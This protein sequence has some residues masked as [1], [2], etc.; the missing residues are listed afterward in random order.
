MNSIVI[1]KINLDDFS[2]SLPEGKI[3]KY[4]LKDRSASKLLFAELNSGSISHHK[5]SDIGTLIP[6]GSGLFL[7]NTK[8]IHARLQM[9]KS[10]GGKAELLLTE[11]V[12]PSVDPQIVMSS[13]SPVVWNCILGG[14]RVL[15]GDI[16]KPENEY[17]Q[18]EAEI[19]SKSD[20]KVTARICWDSNITFSELLGE[21]GK[22]PLPPY[23][24]REAT[25]EDD[26]TYN[27]VYAA[28]EGS[29]A[30]PTAGLH[31]TDKIFKEL[32]SKSVAIDKLSLHVGLGTFIPIS[33]SSIENHDMHSE[34][35]FTDIN[36]IKSINRKINANGK[37]IATGTTSLRTIESIFWYGIKLFNSIENNSGYICDQWT[38][39]D[40]SLKSLSPS[41]SLEIV[42]NHLEKNNI[43]ILNGFTK[44]LIAPG[45]NF[46]IINGLITNY[47]LPKST[48]ILLVAA[49]TGRD[50][51]RK[52][53]DSALN[54]DYRFLSYG[55]SSFLLK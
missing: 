48:L 15:P 19:I 18:F 12:E 45:Y 4:P 32:K 43:G 37:I 47:H 26:I 28:K 17:K 36:V 30:A 52:I 53:Y 24:R 22:V 9:R 46:N 51:W 41:E 34:Q 27:T 16:L 44:L 20:N 13:K 49:F 23:I 54:N 8:V 5:F 10:T 21:C 2:F 39:Y 35:I 38:P 14:K 25:K 6:E 29:V 42:I 1:P 33:G 11:P 40:T 7:N 55:D 3:A 31:F 50:M